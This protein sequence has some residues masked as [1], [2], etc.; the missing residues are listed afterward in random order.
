MVRFDNKSPTEFKF[1]VSKFKYKAE[2]TGFVSYVT[3][4]FKK[5]NYEV[6]ALC[7]TGKQGNMLFKLCFLTR[8]HD[9]TGI[10]KALGMVATDRVCPGFTFSSYVISKELDLKSN[11]V[12]KGTYC[13]QNFI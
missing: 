7:L 4:L 10:R 11:P 3:N 1:D 5:T 6:D 12:I 2:S 9:K 8:E 13:C